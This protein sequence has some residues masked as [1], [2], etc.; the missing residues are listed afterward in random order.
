MLEK[1]DKQLES[2]SDETKL[3]KIRIRRMRILTFK[4]RRVRMRMRIEEFILW[5][6]T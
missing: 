1:N 2:V 4:I 6:G 3:V 5:V